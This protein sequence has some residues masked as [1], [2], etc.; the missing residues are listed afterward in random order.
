MA[1]A[2]VTPAWS[3]AADPRWQGNAT[4]FGLTLAVGFLAVSIVGELA[5]AAPLSVG[6]LAVL[7]DNGPEERVTR[8]LDSVPAGPTALL[9]LFAGAT[10]VRLGPRFRGGGHHRRT[11]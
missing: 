4:L 11:S 10:Y 9:L 5:W 6:V 8:I 2:A 1:A 3:T 7:L